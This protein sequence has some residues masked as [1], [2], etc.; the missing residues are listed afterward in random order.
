MN[1][2]ETEDKELKALLQELIVSNQKLIKGPS[3][4]HSF[5]VGTV[6]AIGATVG[7]AIIVTL[8]ASL[9]SVLAGINLLRPFAQSVLPYVQKTQT[10]PTP[11]ET[12]FLL[13]APSYDAPSTTPTPSASVLTSPLP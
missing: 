2:L 9:L 8:L 7:A 5:F 11:D 4:W 10:R 6:G 1:D 13:P 3:L 12:P